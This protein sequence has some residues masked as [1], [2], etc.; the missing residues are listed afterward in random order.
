MI[1]IRNLSFSYPD[2]TRALNGID[3]GLEKGESLAFIGPNGAGKSTLLLHLNGILRCDNGGRILIDGTELNDTNIKDIREKIGLVFQEPE[4]QLF[5][6][7][8]FEDVAFGPLNMGLPETEVR[9]R[10]REALELTGM[11]GYE[12]RSA[13]HLSFGEKKRVSIATVLSMRPEILVLD[14]PT[15]GLDPWARRN[16]LGLIKRLKSSHT[17]IIATHDLELAELCDR[18][19]MIR[20]GRI[21]EEFELDF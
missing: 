14:E 2:G 6:P 12:E 9:D 16:F 18:T 15:L 8:V 4:D 19:Y 10:V 5:S 3:L 11:Q 17:M 13:H 20:D 7:T 21:L 1:E